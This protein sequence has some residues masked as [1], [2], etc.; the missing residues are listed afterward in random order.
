MSIAYSNYK[1]SFE[2]TRAG[3]YLSY[4]IVK[5][6]IMYITVCIRLLKIVK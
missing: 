1:N 4:T 2:I 5:K 6:L 3:Y